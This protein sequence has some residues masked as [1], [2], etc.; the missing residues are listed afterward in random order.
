MCKH[1]DMTF[2]RFAAKPSEINNFLPFLP[3]SDATKNMPDKELNEILIHAVPNG[4]EK[5]SYL[6]GQDFEM[7]T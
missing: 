5:Q 4:W 7:K 2:K 3:G 6:Q 1:H